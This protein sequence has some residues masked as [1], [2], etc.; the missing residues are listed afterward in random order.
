MKLP[1]KF[2]T[3][4][5]VIIEEVRRFRALS[6]VERIRFIR[7]MLDA[8]ELMMRQSPNAEFLREYTLQQEE[9]AHKTI[10]EFIARHAGPARTSG[11]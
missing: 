8:G 3:D 2:P 5:E 9:L 11:K 6:P 4:E 1:I 7:D 10:K